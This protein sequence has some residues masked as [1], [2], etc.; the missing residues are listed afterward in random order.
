MRQ[1]RS[2]NPL[3]DV[4]RPQN[5]TVADLNP[6]G[7]QWQP[8]EGAASYEVKIG[9]DSH[10]SAPEARVYQVAGRPQWVCPDALPRGT[11]FW[12][13]RSLGCGQDE[14]WSETFR[15]DVSVV[16]GELRVPPA[17][18][19]INQIGDARPRHLLH[20]RRL[21]AF[22]D[23]CLKGDL[24]GEYGRLKAA[25]DE[26]LAEGFMM[27]EPP[28]LPDRE[29]NH[30]EYGR[31]WKAAMVDSRRMGQDAQ[32]FA[33]MYLI[34]GE[35]QLGRAAVDRLLEFSAWDPDG[36]THTFHNNEPH[37][38]VMNLGPRT[39]DWAYDLMSEEERASA[40]RQFIGRG[41]QTLERFRQFNYGITGSD[42]H[43]G[44]LLGFLGE[45]CIVLAGEV[46]EVEE[47]LDFVL[48]TTT[49]MYPW[50]GGKEGGWAQGVS[51][52][53]GYC[54]LFYHFIYGLREAAGVDFYKKPWFRGHGEW[55]LMCV[56][57]NAYL[58][59]F[60]DGRTNGRGSARSSWGLQRH[61]GKIYGDRRLLA[62][63]DQIEAAAGEP[64]VESQGLVSP[65]SFLTQDLGTDSREI[66]TSAATLFR[67]IG[68]LVIRT[69]L[70]EPEKDIRFM[71]RSSPYGTVSHSH[72][73]QNSFAIEAFGEPL[74]IPSG[75]YALYSSA[76]H[77]GWTRQTRAH[78]A[79][80]FDGAGQVVR[81]AQAV[82]A[83]PTF[84]T[85]DRITYALGDASAAYDN[86]VLACRRGVF[87]LDNGLFV[88]VDWLDP[89]YEAIWTWHLHAARRITVDP[90]GRRAE[91]RYD[92]AA[93]D[94]V[95]CHADE[96][97]FKAW[98]GFDVM[99]FGTDEAADLPEE[100]AI[101]H[102]DVSSSMPKQ[103]DVLLSVLH[104]RLVSDAA[105]VVEPLLDGQGEGAR[106][107]LDGR[108]YRVCVAK[109]SGGIDVGGVQA[110]GAAAAVI[111]DAG[112]DVARALLV[113]G[114]HMS[115]D[116]REV[117]EGVLTRVEGLPE[118]PERPRSA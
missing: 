87:C 107:V 75:M 80:T 72:A 66:P 3:I 53:T 116:G 25:A 51:Y 92:K 37:M 65:L 39:Y 60:G 52:S 115:V 48:Q 68:W 114:S 64:I 102:L 13:W 29:K 45:M 1:F 62:H 105:A 30:D 113:G 14:V 104:P 74:A 112:G 32:L 99:P 63:A 4:R 97:L 71:M 50:W 9:P 106:V 56:P 40:R 31:V 21:A 43:S 18:M 19:V 83:F 82:G 117:A 90:A 88:L 24:A 95:F 23:A 89:A 84:H 20:Q 49:V 118:T 44:R 85:D 34:S 22:R 26:R 36:A 33:L 77:H 101:H 94:V 100:A 76:H 108:T 111:E 41:N 96:L 15:F 81:S 5:G 54:Y 86:R 2:P 69:N 46:D 109:G 28:F 8:V 17:R 7:F 38:S 61:L 47:W 59:P 103:R 57:P 6:P 78:N 11:Y 98:D 93:L 42:N 58:V 73:D 91:I 12:A 35:E 110:D 55:R 70:G 10:L 67:D 79:V 27:T 16:T